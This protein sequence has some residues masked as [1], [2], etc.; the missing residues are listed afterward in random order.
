[1]PRS[2]VGLLSSVRTPNVLMILLMSGDTLCI[3]DLY[4][5]SV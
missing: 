4:L 1:M 2:F 5:T 3:G